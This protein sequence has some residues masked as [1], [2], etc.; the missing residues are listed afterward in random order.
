M[1]HK[2]ILIYFNCF[3]YNKNILE[4][5]FQ[6]GSFFYSDI[7]KS[8]MF[9]CVD[10]QWNVLSSFP[11]YAQG[12]RHLPALVKTMCK[13]ANVKLPRFRILLI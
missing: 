6:V 3:L 7:H 10:T 4:N 1:C 12:V 8:W 2:F 9:V 11:S 5:V 13:T